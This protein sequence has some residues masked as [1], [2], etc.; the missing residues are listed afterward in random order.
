MSVLKDHCADCG[1][2]FVRPEDSQH[3]QCPG[4]RTDDMAI[5]STAH[6]VTLNLSIDEARRVL[7]DLYAI[8]S[9]DIEETNTNRQHVIDKIED[10]L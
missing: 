4:C 1:S 2:K 9:T 7:L 8:R 10:Q 5:A 3:E 6:S